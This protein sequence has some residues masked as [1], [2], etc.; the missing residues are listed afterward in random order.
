MAV[1]KAIPIIIRQTLNAKVSLNIADM[2][3]VGKF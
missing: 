3:L 2:T 1:L